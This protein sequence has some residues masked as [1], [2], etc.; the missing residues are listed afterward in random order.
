MDNRVFGHDSTGINVIF[1]AG[2]TIALGIIDV[3]F[4]KLNLDIAHRECI[5]GSLGVGEVGI[6]DYFAEFIFSHTL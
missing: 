1:V 6:A 5:C 3:G 2:N 4:I